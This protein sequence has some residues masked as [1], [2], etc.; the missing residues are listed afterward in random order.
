MLGLVCAQC[1]TPCILPDT[2][3]CSSLEACQMCSPLSLSRGPAELQEKSHE[4]QNKMQDLEKQ[5]ESLQ[6]E[7]EQLQC[8]CRTLKLANIAQQ[9]VPLLDDQVRLGNLTMHH[10]C[11]PSGFA[12]HQNG[13]EAA[14]TAGVWLDTA[15]ELSLTLLRV[16][17]S[18]ACYKA[19][20]DPH[21]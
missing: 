5:L 16:Q 18:A 9:A 1:I 3:L 2:R 21:M 8:Q 17:V 6:R 11:K 12:K 7:N 14:A 20:C 19:L 13:N 4:S 15:S 10:F